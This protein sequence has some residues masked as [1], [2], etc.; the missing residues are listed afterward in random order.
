MNRAAAFFIEVILMLALNAC[1]YF[2]ALGQDVNPARNFP[3]IFA[4]IEWNTISG[5]W[6]VEY[7]RQFYTTGQIA[8]GARAAYIAKYDYGNMEILSSSNCCET[9]THALLMSTGSYYTGKKKDFSG[10]F[11]H[12]GLG[13]GLTWLKYQSQSTRVEK[14]TIKPAF[15]FGPGW[16]FKIGERVVLRCKGTASFGPFEGSFT[17]TTVSLGF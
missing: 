14:T 7:E 11:V 4:G 1:T 15:E 5:S 17:S 16:Q 8:I 9:A 13:A 6:G 3:G 2:G 12:T 10:F